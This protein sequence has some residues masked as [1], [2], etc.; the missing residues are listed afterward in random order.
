M[1]GVTGISIDPGLYGNGMNVHENFQGDLY[2]LIF[3]HQHLGQE[4]SGIA[5]MG[6]SGEKIS[7]RTHRGL[8]R[9]QFSND[10]QG[11]RPPLGLGHVSSGL[12][13][14]YVV[15][16]SAFPPLALC[17]A[18][19]IQNREELIAK[20][21][22][23]GH[24]LERDDDISLIAQVLVSVGWNNNHD[25][26][27]NFREAFA[28]V[29]SEVK[30]SYAILVMTDKRIFAYVGKDGHET[31][32]IGK[33]KGAVV[34]AS[35]STGFFNQ[36]Y[37]KERD[38]KAG[39][40]YV[41]KNGLAECLASVNGTQ[42]EEGRICS[43]KWVYTANPA[44]KIF[45]ITSAEVRRR[46]G[47]RL[48]IKDI[49]NGFIPDVVIPVPDS[50]R[51][52]ALGYKQEYD[53]QMMAGTISKV[54]MI[55]EV[56]VKYPYASRSYTPA[57][58]STRKI[59]ALKKLVPIIEEVYKGKRIVVIDDSIVRGTQTA[60]D[61][62]PKLKVNGVGEIHLRISNPKLV[63]ICRWGKANKKMDELA[64]Y[65]Y[66]KKL[67]RKAEEIALRLGVDSCYFN[68]ISDIAEA[69]GIPLDRL[70]ADCSQADQ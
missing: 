3:Y 70:C 62:V 56:L 34:V 58:Q 25:Y 17:F 7:I 9:P 10:M 38:V 29:Q 47:A 31:L 67:V 61:L 39:E 60:N 44:A 6:D 41:L 15:E 28:A 16:R 32:S 4:Y 2:W 69:I 30:G 51:F 65:D 68:Q 5:T 63:N 37:V 48:A 18:G 54:P 52:H 55:D 50:G 64:A 19:F 27:W 22:K 21:V 20:I 43:F 1:S 59:E 53:R 40:L 12:R 36:G 24:G 35:E 42:S 13:E 26:E 8:F 49:E 45:G 11:F 57:K 66:E 14:P 46:M 33:K 23:S